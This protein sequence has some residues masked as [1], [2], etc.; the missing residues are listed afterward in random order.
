MRPL[1]VEDVAQTSVAVADDVRRLI[2]VLDYRVGW[3]PQPGR[4]LTMNAYSQVMPSLLDEA[5]RSMKT[6]LWRERS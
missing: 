3:K 5:D 4:E 2:R 6:A 1:V